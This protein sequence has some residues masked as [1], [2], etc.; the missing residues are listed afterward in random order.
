MNIQ[1]EVIQSLIQLNRKT[2]RELAGVADTT[3]ADFV[4]ISKAQDALN[5]QFHILLQ[6]K[7]EMESAALAYPTEKSNSVAIDDNAPIAPGE[8]SPETPININKEKRGRGAEKQYYLKD[9]SQRSSFV[10]HLQRIF[11]AHYIPGKKFRLM[12]GSEVKAPSFLACL[13]DLGI[14]LG[15]T[16]PEVPVKDFCQMVT[17]AVAVCAKTCDN[18]KDFNTAYNTIQKSTREWKPFT[19]D[20]DRYY[21]INVCFHKLKQEQVPQKHKADYNRWLNLY[22]MVERIY[23]ETKA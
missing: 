10:A 12:D 3:S 22:T 11:L 19:D 1:A 21:G 7:E 8:N 18:V 5:E 14:K 17:E 23:N 15:I 2:L 9:A 20:E 16:S 6:Q 13:Y 4:H